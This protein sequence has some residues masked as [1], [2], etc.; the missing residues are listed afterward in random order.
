VDLRNVKRAL[1]V[2]IFVGTVLSLINQYEAVLSFS[3]TRSQLIRI[4][5]NYVVPFLVSLYSSV[6]SSKER[7][8]KTA[9]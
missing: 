1:K 9:A 4:G 5:M 8:S 7:N 2:S 3:F 6:A